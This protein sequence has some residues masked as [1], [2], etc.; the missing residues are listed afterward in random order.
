MGFECR[1]VWP[2]LEIAVA[3]CALSTIFHALPA[4]AS[5]ETAF[6]KALCDELLHP[7][8]T[9]EELAQQADR[10]LQ[11][12][13]KKLD[14]HLM[15]NGAVQTADGGPNDDYLGVTWI[16]DASKARLGWL[17]RRL[18]GAHTQ[19]EMNKAIAN[20]SQAEA[21][22]IYQEGLPFANWLRLT[23]EAVL[24]HDN[25]P[26]PEGDELALTIVTMGEMRFASEN[27]AVIMA[28]DENG[29]P[30]PWAKLWIRDQD[31]GPGEA[32]AFLALFGQI[33]LK[34]GHSDWVKT[35]LLDDHLGGEMRGV[36]RRY[37][38]YISHEG[39]SHTKQTGDPWEVWLGKHFSTAVSQIGGLYR[40]AELA[41]EL[42]GRAIEEHHYHE[43]SDYQAAANHYR[44]VAD[45]LVKMLGTHWN[46][47]MNTFLYTLDRDTRYSP[48]RDVERNVMTVTSLVQAKSIHLPIPLTDDRV[49]ASM[50]ALE[51]DMRSIMPP[52]SVDPRTGAVPMSR[53]LKDDWVGEEPKPHEEPGPQVEHKPGKY[54]WFLVNCDWG[55]AYATDAPEFLSDGKIVITTRSEGFF[56]ALFLGHRDQDPHLRP[57]TTLVDGDPA[58]ADIIHAIARK[59]DAYLAMVNRAVQPDGTTAEGFDPVTGKPMGPANLT[60]NSPEYERFVAQWKA[61]HAAIDAWEARHRTANTPP[62]KAPARAN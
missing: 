29:K 15:P 58:Y 36:L 5:A 54:A 48:N 9:R 47:D 2:R 31:D 53:D 50:H 56:K 38:E 17:E 25:G 22:K 35:E 4:R 34:A 60:W 13:R 26:S 27:G 20:L 23:Q 16:R 39:Q 10:N 8:P 30:L 11:F 42:S 32:S 49:L 40:A 37:A 24:A 21:E 51:L 14:E 43:A 3:I 46:E 61:M 1:Q 12:M 59:A 19:E 52:E 7:L 55:N 41:G 44:N 62:R 45:E 18:G 33:A 6:S 28:T 57:G